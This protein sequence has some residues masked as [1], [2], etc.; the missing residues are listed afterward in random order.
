MQKDTVFKVRDDDTGLHLTKRGAFPFFT[1]R[2]NAYNS[3]AACKTAIKNRLSW[4]Y[5]TKYKNLSIVE[6]EL[7]PTGKETKYKE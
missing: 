5:K 2:G 6:Y 7:V 1:V 4:R 3:M